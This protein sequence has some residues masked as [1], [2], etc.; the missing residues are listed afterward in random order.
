[1]TVGKESPLKTYFMTRNRWLFIRRNAAPTYAL[2]FACYYLLIAVPV[3]LVWSMLKGR[4][5]LA[6]AAFRAVWWNLSHAT[7][8]RDLGVRLPNA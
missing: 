2:V 7:T 1:M 4:F 5:D 6:G 3:L 8:S